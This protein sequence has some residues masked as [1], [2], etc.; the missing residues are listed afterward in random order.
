MYY[1]L[2]LDDERVPLDVKWIDLPLV[3]WIIARSFSDFV[4]IINKNGLPKII[5]FD[6]DLA[7]EHYREFINSKNGEFNYNK[8]KEKT[9]YDC[10]KFLIDY[11]IDNNLDLPEYYIHTMNPI[12]RENMNSLLE[13][14]KKSKL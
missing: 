14:Y 4:D 9:G 5:S 8:M 12:G 7:D 11:C 10:V 6:H 1:N 2:F 13:S 3:N